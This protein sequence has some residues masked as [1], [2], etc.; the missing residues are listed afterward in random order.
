MSVNLVNPLGV[1]SQSIFGSSA[2]SGIALKLGI[3][4]DEFQTIKMGL[5]CGPQQYGMCN[6]FIGH[7]SCEISFG[8]DNNVVIGHQAG[9][10]LQGD[11]NVCLGYGAGLGVGLFTSNVQIGSLSSGTDFAVAVGSGTSAIGRWSIAVGCEAKSIGERSIAIGESTQAKGAGAF[12]LA[13][14]VRG[15]FLPGSTYAVQVDGDVLSLTNGCVLG[16]CPRILSETNT[17]ASLKDPLTQY[18]SWKIALEQDDL[19]IRSAKG[20][21]VRFVEGY[22]S[23]VLNFTGSHCVRWASSDSLEEAMSIIPKE[24]I[25]D[26]LKNHRHPLSYILVQITEPTDDDAS[27]VQSMT[28]PD[29]EEDGAL[30]VVCIWK[31]DRTDHNASSSIFGAI[32]AR[33]GKGECRRIGHLRFEAPAECAEEEE[34]VTV[35]ACGDGLIWVRAPIGTSLPV[36]TLLTG[37]DVPGL[38]RP[39]GHTRLESD[40]VAKTTQSVCFRVSELRLVPCSYK[41]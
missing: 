11:A 7:R 22:R 5:P 28:D 8:G 34:K 24:I 36:G 21:V 20:A 41:M 32:A 27:S 14:R 19:V 31:R 38:S 1:G 33:Q 17:A 35:H 39:Q 25:D 10:Q 9:Y 13:N 29:P 12:T 6:V 18:P 23:G 40:T 16:F 37:D 30:P 26:N 15:R 2:T 3:S 4:T